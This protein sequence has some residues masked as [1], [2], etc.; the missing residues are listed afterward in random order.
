MQIKNYED[1]I[2]KLKPKLADYLELK[3][4]NT[5][6]NFTCIHP[7]HDDEKPSMGIVPGSNG[8]KAKCFSCGA[9]PDI[10][11]ACSWLE[12]KP[13]SGPL[14]ITETV[15]YLAQLFDI[16]VELKE[17]TEEEKYRIETFAAYKHAANYIATHP[18]PSSI[19]DMNRRKWNVIQCKDRLIGSVDSFDN[20]K[21]YLKGLGYSVS[22]LENI[23]LLN[24]NLFNENCLIFTI[25]DEHGRPVGFSARNLLWETNKNSA[26]YQ[27]TSAKCTIYEKSKR[28]YNIHSAKRLPGTAFLTEGC[29]DSE[30]MIQVGK[31]KVLGICGTGFTDYH[32]IELAKNN[33]KDITLLMDGDEAGVKAT[34][35]IIEKFS[36]HR[37]FTLKIILI[38]DEYDPE[39]FV[40]EKGVEEFEKLKIWTAFEWKLS[41]FDD[42]IDTHLIRKEIVPLIATEPSPIEREVMINALSERIG[43]TQTSIMEEV[44]QVLNANDR[45][46]KSERDLI[47]KEL[48]TDLSHNPTDWRY[49]INEATTQLD[50]LADTYTEDSFSPNIYIREI[51]RQCEEELNPE[52]NGMTFNFHKWND[53]NEAVM[54]NHQATLNVIGGQANTGKTAFMSNLA[55]QLADNE[56]ED[57]FVIFHTID[58]TLGQFTNRLIT[59][60][61]FEKY[62][63]ITLNQIKNP[64]G[65]DN[66]QKIKMARNYAYEKFKSLVERQRILVRGGESSPSAST[67][68]YGEEM[69]KYALKARKDARIIYFADNF[70]RFRDFANFEE[71]ARFK[72]LSNTVKDIAKRYNIPIWATMEY[73][74]TVGTGR[75]TNNSISESVAMEY[76][77][78]LIM[79]LYND[80]HV[81]NQLGEEPEMYFTRQDEQ[82]R[83]F[84]APRIEAIFGKNKLNSFK[85]SLYFDFFPDQ[86]R[87]NPVSRAIVDEDKDKIKAER[88]KM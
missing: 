2:E 59:Q 45:K 88:K 57:N 86:S 25:C 26:K 38:P 16:Q 11:D 4:I 21:K 79:H 76:D 7:D 35:N 1:V 37:D 39:E 28:L 20:Y 14:F 58:D 70:H 29:A 87:M 27:N 5:R 80:L 66:A 61:A 55:L 81:K 51:E 54:G 23:D 3:G 84:K 50:A 77:A 30:G 31:G 63:F 64:N 73:N 15:S 67:V 46:K 48:M 10:F 33:I 36:T 74:K 18:S 40:A 47:L 69:I 65:Y 8:G 62:A 19:A 60:L 32:I 75:P 13:Q 49:A 82:G 44:N 53:F 72:K 43:I 78:N 42:R 41:S 24:P 17:L 12:N 52:E 22:F 85:S 68:A 9:T 34:N 71:R 83:F 56:K 6:K